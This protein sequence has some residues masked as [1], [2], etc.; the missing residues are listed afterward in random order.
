VPSVV[1]HQIGTAASSRGTA[2]QAAEK[3]L[4]ELGWT[5]LHPTGPAPAAP[6]TPG[7]WEAPGGV[8]CWERVVV[9]GP[10]GPGGPA[11]G[12]PCPL[13][14]YV[15]PLKD[16]EWGWRAWSPPDRQVQTRQHGEPAASSTAARLAADQALAD[17]GWSI[18]D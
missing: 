13:A 18:T 1:V 12:H 15:Y 2:L 8:A 4:A 9:P 5:V 3:T 11:D 14:A 7:P 6:P 17:L 16:S 10:P